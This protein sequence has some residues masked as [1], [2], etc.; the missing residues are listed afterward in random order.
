M[1]SLLLKELIFDFYLFSLVLFGN[2]VWTPF[3]RC[4]LIW[5]FNGCLVCGLFAWM[6]FLP[7][8]SLWFYCVDFFGLAL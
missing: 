5:H 3:A 4:L 2:L 1:F 8:D 7:A 6:F